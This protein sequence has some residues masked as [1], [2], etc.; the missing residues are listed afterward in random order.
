MKNIYDIIVENKI[1]DKNSIYEFCKSCIRQEKLFNECNTLDF[2]SNNNSFYACYSSDE[3][4]IKLNLDMM[5]EEFKNMCTN[6]NLKNNEKYEYINLKI[7]QFILHEIEHA[8]QEKELKSH[9]SNLEIMLLSCAKLNMELWGL[10]KDGR[11]KYKDTYIYNPSERMAD[12]K[13]YSK[14]L[15]IVESINANLDVGNILKILKREYVIK[16][17]SGYST[18]LCPTEIYLMETELENIWQNLSF[19]NT[20]R[21]IMNEKAKKEYNLKKRMLLGLPIDREEYKMMS[22]LRDNI[23]LSH[24]R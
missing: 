11:K 17:L 6:Y 20:N 14:V 7:I 1:I 16:N 24:S 23:T 18:D 5:I 22:S 13:S 9:I 15:S 8:K 4:K 2:C 10:I 19:Y 3:K 21:N 12:I